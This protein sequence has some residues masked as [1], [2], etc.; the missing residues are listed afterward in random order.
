MSHSADEA[1]LDKQDL[2]QDL[3]YVSK[4][5]LHLFDPCVSLSLAGMA[6]CNLIWRNQDGSAR[7]YTHFWTS[8]VFSMQ[9]FPRKNGRFW[10]TPIITSKWS[11]DLDF[12]RDNFGI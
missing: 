12:V 9:V 2:F 8:P 10:M 1:E 5:V 3:L 6:H 11:V 7:R 4:F